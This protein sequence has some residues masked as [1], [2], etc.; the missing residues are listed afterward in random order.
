[1]RRSDSLPGRGPA[2]PRGRILHPGEAARVREQ[3]RVLSEK[4]T[5]GV[6]LLDPGRN[7]IA[8][9]K[10]LRNH[11]DIGLQEAKDLTDGAKKGANPLLTA[12]LEV[13]QA[14]KLGEDIEAAG[15]QVAFE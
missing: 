6:R 15:G 14:R 3:E 13:R 1:M 7:Q 10:V 8:V 12:D 5:V 2:T 9:I 11:F 4:P